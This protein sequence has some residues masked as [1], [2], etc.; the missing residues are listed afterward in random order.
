MAKKSV[1]VSIALA[2]A[3][4]LALTA[5]GT[6]EL[7]VSKNTWQDGPYNKPLPRTQ[8]EPTKLGGGNLI[9][10]GTEG[11]NQG[12]GG[13]TLP[14]NKFLWRATLDTL[15]FLPLSS[16]DP[17]GGVIITDWG[18]T[19]EGPSERFKVTAYITSAELK[20]Q[21]LRVVVNR[22]TLSDA[23]QW[24][25]APVAQDTPRQL[26]NAILTRARVIKTGETPTQ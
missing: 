10:L 5:C 2:A 7:E 18:S 6:S 8:A 15:A 3:C 21:S 11:E 19:P 14:V 16:T 13:A 12:S 20:P 4:G 25:A 23:G 17:Y 22:Q 26:E 24:V 9:S 1:I